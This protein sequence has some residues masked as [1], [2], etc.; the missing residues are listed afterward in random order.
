MLGWIHHVEVMEPECFPEQLTDYTPR[1]TR[2]TGRPKLR[3][4]NVTDWKVETLILMANYF[5]VHMVR[6]PKMQMK[7]TPESAEVFS[8]SSPVKNRFFSPS[9]PMLRSK[10]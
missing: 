4:R 3:C 9:V 1:R 6:D 5:A 10:N 7:S 2:S 8:N